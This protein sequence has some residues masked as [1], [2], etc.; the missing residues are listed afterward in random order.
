VRQALYLSKLFLPNC[1]MVDGHNKMDN[2]GKI[3]IISLTTKVVKAFECANLFYTDFQEDNVSRATL[4]L[5]LATL[6]L[7]LA[8]LT[9]MSATL[10]LMLATLTLMLV[11]LTLMLATLTLMLVTLTLMLVTL[12]LMLAPGAQNRR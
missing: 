10:T 9:L 12:T 5:M 1:Q 4:T 2:M 8:T 3:K 11:T 7:M 6:T